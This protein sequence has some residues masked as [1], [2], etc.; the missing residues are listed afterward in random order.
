M[1][2]SKLLDSQERM[3]LSTL[4]MARL[5]KSVIQRLMLEEGTTIAELCKETEFSVPTVTKVVGELIEEGIA[6]EKGKI[7][8]AGGRRPSIYG[9]NPNSA[10]F[11]GVDV[12]EIVQALVYKISRTNLFNYLQDWILCCRT[13]QNL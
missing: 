10:F 3:S 11:L 4:K 7:D 13:L 2:L 8:T 5:K 6:F 12:R 1:I 9:I